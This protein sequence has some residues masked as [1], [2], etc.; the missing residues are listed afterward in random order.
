MN[1]AF[2]HFL[3][4]SLPCRKPYEQRSAVG[5]NARLVGGAVSFHLSAPNTPVVDDKALF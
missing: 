3:R 5:L 1:T 4:F 2:Q